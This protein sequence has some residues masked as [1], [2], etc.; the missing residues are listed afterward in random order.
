MEGSIGLPV[1]G[2]RSSR[3]CYREL[4][5]RTLVRLGRRKANPIRV[6]IPVGS[7]GGSFGMGALPRIAGF[8]HLYLSSSSTL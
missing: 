5:G 7:C 2:G 1:V 3:V 6:G 8:S 4:I